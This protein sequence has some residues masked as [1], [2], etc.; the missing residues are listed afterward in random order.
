[1]TKPFYDTAAAVL[2]RNRIRDLNGRKT[3]TDI[4]KAAGFQNANFVSM[5]KNGNSKI[6]I[7]RVPDLARSIEVDPALLMRLSL[8]Q[9]IGP[10]GAAAVIS[11]FGTPVT[12]NEM[13]W[14]TEIRGASENSDPSCT[15][16]ARNAIR[17]IFGK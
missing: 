6:P 17:G 3:Q 5:L 14:L 10:A 9:S 16:K 15:A 13:T 1:M 4:A 7:D 8:D 2:L 11:V 12:C